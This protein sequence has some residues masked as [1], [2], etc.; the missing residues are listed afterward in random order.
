MVL[1]PS[2][3]RLSFREPH[4]PVIN[5]Q[6]GVEAMKK[7]YTEAGWTQRQQYYEEG[8]SPEWLALYRDANALLTVDPA[9]AEAQAVADR[10]LDLSVSS[11]PPPIGWHHQVLVGLPLPTNGGHRVLPAISARHQLGRPPHLHRAP[12]LGGRPYACASR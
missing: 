7:Y 2:A 1:Q 4:P 11:H 6:E 10:W 8:P 5:M 3:R 12:R 9:S